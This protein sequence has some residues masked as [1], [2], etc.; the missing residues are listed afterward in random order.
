LNLPLIHRAIKLTKAAIVIFG[1]KE[2]TFS[3]ALIRNSLHYAAVQGLDTTQLCT[4]IDLDP[5]LL[6]H[7]DN[8]VTGVTSRALWHALI[9]QTGDRNVGLHIGEQFNLAAL[10]IV[11]YVLFNCQT[12]G[13]VLDKLSRYMCLFSQGVSLRII[14]LLGEV[15][16]DWVVVSDVQNYLLE[17]PRQ[18][19]EVTMTSLLTTAKTLTGQTLRPLAVSFHHARPNDILEHQRI[20]GTTVQFAQ[21]VNRVVLDAACLNWAVVSANASLLSTFEQHAEAMLIEL[22]QTHTYSYQVVREITHLMKGDIPTIDTIAHCL[23][24]IVRNLQRSLQAEGTS[25]QQLLN[26]TRRELALRYLKKPDTSI[27]DI[28]FLLGFSEPSAFHRAFKR[29]TGQ[30]PQKYRSTAA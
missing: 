28:A 26:D 20:F 17:E 9:Q 16:C 2:A 25:Y 22:N 11:G 8:R 27:H 13:Q 14:P 4:A 3:I 1:M 7:P 30:T 29:W 19:I 21:P 5:T 10:G 24:T 12:F 6:N 18:A 23:M 15:V